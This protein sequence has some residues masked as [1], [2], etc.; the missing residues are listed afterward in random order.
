VWP[1]WLTDALTGKASLARAFWGYGLGLSIGYSLLGLFIDIQN[2]PLTAAYLV[3]GLALG[4]LQTI[5]LWRCAHNSKSRFLG[6]LVR[7]AMLF[8]FIMVGIM[9]YVL[10]TNAGSLLPPV[11]RWT[12]P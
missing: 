6:R 5:V 9:L 11:N 7:A 12:G 3:V 8:G 2:V 4:V 10:V 1:R